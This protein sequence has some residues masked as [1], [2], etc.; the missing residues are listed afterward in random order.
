MCLKWSLK[1][2]RHTWMCIFVVAKVVQTV[3]SVTVKE[4]STVSWIVQ[5]G[6]IDRH[7]R[8]RRLSPRG[9]LPQPWEE[10]AG[11]TSCRW[12]W[13]WHGEAKG[14][15]FIASLAISSHPRWPQNVGEGSKGQKYGARRAQ[16]ACDAATGVIND[17]GFNGK[18]WFYLA[19][20]KSCNTRKEL[21]YTVVKG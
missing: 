10:S 14:P 21:K 17:G 6:L 16:Q 5:I 9:L 7:R 1:S 13:S 12:K 19:Q 3:S 8:C 20:R 4:S 2:C 18:R 11:T 15:F